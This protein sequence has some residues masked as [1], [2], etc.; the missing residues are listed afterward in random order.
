MSFMLLKRSRG[1]LLGVHGRLIS[2]VN[3]S[4]GIDQRINRDADTDR[5]KPPS[6]FKVTSYIVNHITSFGLLFCLLPG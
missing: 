1:H 4:V 3:S 5:F 6:I 2:A